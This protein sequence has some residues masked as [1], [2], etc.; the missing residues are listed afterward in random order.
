MNVNNYVPTID[1]GGNCI[2]VSPLKK[3][4]ITLE[5]E[6]A[7]KN[8]GFFYLVN[9]GIKSNI[10][11]DITVLSKVFFK[12]SIS[13]K[14]LIEHSNSI[15]NIGYVGIGEE[16]SAYSSGDLHEG[17]D[18][19]REDFYYGNELIK[20]DIRMISNQWPQN[21]NDFKKVFLE[22]ANSVYLLAKNLFSFFGD[23]LG[24]DE[25]RFQKLVNNPMQLTRL[26]YYPPVIDANNK[27]YGTGPHTDHECFT[28]L[29]Q[30]DKVEALEVLDLHDNWVK[31]PPIKYSYVVNI[32][33]LLSLWT[34]GTFKSTMHRVINKS[35]SE[36]YSIPTF[37]GPNHDS[38]IEVLPKYDTNK[39]SSK[40]YT[41]E[42]IQGLNDGN[43]T[44]KENHG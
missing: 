9:H 12:Q 7:C 44:S 11:D 30:C 19:V 14:K 10:I 2:D 21:N 4:N 17:F 40:I 34:G 28:L 43:F 41:F 29:L 18:F 23:I 25:S 33:D 37:I 13:E 35:G 8:V 16:G 27:S 31:V 39:T 36:R 15:Y 22:Y 42:Y 1:L 32:G 38:I 24:V 3:K 26:M 6:K 20:G 5:I